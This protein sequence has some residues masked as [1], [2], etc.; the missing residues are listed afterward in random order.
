MNSGC[1]KVPYAPVETPS[2]FAFALVLVK[3][4][5]ITIKMEWPTLP[6][7][8]NTSFPVTSTSVIG[9]QTGN[10]VFSIVGNVGH[11][12]FIVIKHVYTKTSTK[13]NIIGVSTGA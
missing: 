2:I 4:C 12:I 5:F 10:Y 8:L 11:S 13:A 7:M 9:G 3:R 6:S 1:S